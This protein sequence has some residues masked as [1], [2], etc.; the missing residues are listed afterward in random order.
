VRKL[1]II[2]NAWPI[3]RRRVHISRPKCCYFPEPWTRH[4][5]GEHQPQV[6]V[7]TAGVYLV[8]GDNHTLSLQAVVSGE[9]KGQDTVGGVPT[10]DTAI[11]AVYLGPQINF[12]WS[13]KLSAL[14]GAD[15]PVSI[16]TTGQQL[17]PNYRV[18]AAVTW[19]F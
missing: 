19:R 3:I 12:T 17:V 2:N 16:V 14:I 9:S 1:R 8:L 15:L 18:R 4:L 11:T 10:D 6:L 5:D 13:S 7:G